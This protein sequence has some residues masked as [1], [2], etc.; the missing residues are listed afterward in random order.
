M[1]PELGRWLSLD[2][3]LGKLSQ[4]QS[5]NRYV[6]C[7][8]NPLRFVDPTGQG[9]WSWLK[10]LFF[11]DDYRYS[12]VDTQVETRNGEPT[13]VN[14]WVPP[15]ENKGWQVS[16]GSVLVVGGAEV[17]LAYLGTDFTTAISSGASWLGSKLSSRSAGSSA[18][19]EGCTSRPDCDQQP[20]GL[21]KCT[22]IRNS[23][24]WARQHSRAAEHLSCH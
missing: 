1:D 6:Y 20:L 9:F 11:D 19:G 4:P 2:P 3:E 12:P 14:R 17:G 15:W 13:L 24:L 22:E 16:V 5:M 7:V 18:G 8:N 10:G 21:A 23:I